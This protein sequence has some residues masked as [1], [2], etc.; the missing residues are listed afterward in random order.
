MHLLGDSQVICL[1]MQTTTALPDNP[2]HIEW[3]ETKYI[4]K[5]LKCRRYVGSSVAVYYSN[6]SGIA[7]TCHL[8]EY[9]IGG[10]LRQKMAHES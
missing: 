3:G 1:K 7:G 8:L 6:M 2:T 5:Q 4:R 9:F 10:F